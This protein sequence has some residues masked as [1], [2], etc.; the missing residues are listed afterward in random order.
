MNS[1]I[2]DDLMGAVRE[3]R[4]AHRRFA[5][6]ASLVAEEEAEEA[7]RLAEAEATIDAVRR[8][9]EVLDRSHGS[10]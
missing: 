2:N 8:E 7:K 4:H 6:I 5:R 9:R 3:Q 1:E 10:R